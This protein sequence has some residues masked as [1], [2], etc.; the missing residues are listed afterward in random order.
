MP[1]AKS[2]DRKTVLSEAMLVF[3]AKG[4]ERASIAELEKAM[5]INRFSIYDAF[6]DKKGLFLAC[7]ETYGEEISQRQTACLLDP[8]GAAG[9]QKFFDDLLL[10]FS[11]NSNQGCLIINTLVDL[12]GLDSDI[13]EAITANLLFVEERMYEAAHSAIASGDFVSTE[14]PRTLARQL[15]SVTQTVLAFSKS[16]HGHPIAKAAV[17]GLLSSLC[18][19]APS[20]T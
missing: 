17:T 16:P 13:D 4:Y 10:L 7:I 5:G 18:S 9:V 1:R 8:G 6:G 3:W 14:S 15:L 11:G 12:S 20:R 19:P 2:Y